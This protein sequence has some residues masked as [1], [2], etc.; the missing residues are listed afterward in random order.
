M[1]ASDTP[2]LWH[3]THPEAVAQYSTVP[4][5]V[6]RQGIYTPGGELCGYELLFRAA[7]LKGACADLWEAEGQDLATEHVIAAAFH[8]G[9]D[10]THG[11]DASVNFT[12]NYLLT[13]QDLHCDPATVIIEIVESTTVH[14]L[15]VD[16]VLELRDQGFRIALDDFTA[17]ES[18][19]ELLPHADFVKIDQRD[20]ARHGPEI[21]ERARGNGRR[22]VAECVETPSELR[23]LTALGFDQIQG[24]LFERAE[25]LSIPSR[26]G[27]AFRR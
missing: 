27:R 25:V 8:Q 13:H 17:T 14:A 5:L 4:T 15:L 21:V 12:G 7:G 9:A 6:G 23:A 22:L 24:H 18:Q 2:R 19:C 26:D 1:T 16:R 3:W 10:I 11:R 20:I